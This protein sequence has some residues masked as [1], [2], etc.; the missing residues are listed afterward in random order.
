MVNKD[1]I[2]RYFEQWFESNFGRLPN[3]TNEY[4]STLYKAFTAGINLSGN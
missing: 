2:S 4:D 3:L 1:I